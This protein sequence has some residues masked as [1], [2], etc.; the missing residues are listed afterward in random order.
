MLYYNTGTNEAQIC[1]LRFIHNLIVFIIEQFIKVKM[2]LDRNIKEIR[3][4]SLDTAAYGKDIG[5]DLSELVNQISSINR[6]FYLRVG[7][8]EPRNTYD[9][10]EKLVTSYRHENVF[11]FLH[12]PV[13]SADNSVLEAMNREYTIVIDTKIGQYRKKLAYSIYNKVK[14]IGRDAIIVTADNINPV[15][16][17]NL[18]CD[19]VVFTGCPRVSIDDEDKFNM[20]VLTPIEFEQLFGFKGNNKYIMDEIV[21]VDSYS[22]MR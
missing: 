14:S 20:P 2:E 4:S 7:M 17:Q 16:F 19:A 13:Q 1:I 3:I 21:G 15:D 5:T 11:K 12:L 9:I 8:L 10:L 6:D 18:M 22:P